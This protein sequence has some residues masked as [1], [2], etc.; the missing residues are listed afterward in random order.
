[1]CA[2]R[3]ILSAVK[4][5]S[6]QYALLLLGTLAFAA[7]DA[8]VKGQHGGARNAVGDISAT[9]ALLPFLAGALT[10][11]RRVFVRG[12]VVGATSTL[13]ALA[14]YALVRAGL[15]SGVGSHHLA[16]LAS[17][18]NRWLLLG[19]FGGAALGA[20]GAHLASRRRW[21]IVAGVAGSLLVLE[22]L[23]RIVWALSRGESPRLLLPS[24]VVWA[25]EIGC[26]C[27]IVL[28]YHVWGFARPD[29]R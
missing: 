19:L 28:G 2:T 15:S 10:T 5:T 1:L 17:L 16:P 12:A 11:S 20:I 29:T 21:S 27:L 13:I 22:P 3:H 14:A 6:S 25:V 9:W 7:T 4:R 24:P 26:G 18:G 8:V 23:T